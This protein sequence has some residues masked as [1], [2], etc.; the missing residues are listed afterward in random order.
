MKSRYRFVCGKMETLESLSLQSVP[1]SPLARLSVGPR[2]HSRL[3]ASLSSG[4]RY[5]CVVMQL[6][7]VIL[8]QRWGKN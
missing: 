2:D 3:G 8:N 6:G 4:K 1:V 7:T 5:Q